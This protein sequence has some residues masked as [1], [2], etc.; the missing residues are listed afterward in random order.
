ME[1]IVGIQHRTGVFQDK[2]YDNYYIYVVNDEKKDENTVGVCPSFYKV[3][4]ALINEIVAPDQIKR[5]VGM[6]CEV[7]F[8]SYKNVALFNVQ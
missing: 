8:D 4:A 7:L 5:L 1:K 6:H 2:P 3:K